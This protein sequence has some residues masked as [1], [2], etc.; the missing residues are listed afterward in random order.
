MIAILGK[1]GPP[2]ER[3]VLAGLNAV[4]YETEPPVTRR[5]GNAIIG[6][7]PRRGLAHEHLSAR[8][9]WACILWGQLD[10][11]QVLRRE[12]GMSENDGTN[13]ADVVE[14]AIR[15][16]GPTVVRRFRG[17]FAGVVTDGRSLWAFRDHVGFAPLFFRDDANAFTVAGISRQV[18]VAAGIREEPNLDVLEVMLFSSQ[19]SGTLPALKGVKRLAQGCVATF[20]DAA[21]LRIERFWHPH[22]LLETRRIS[23]PDAREEFLALLKQASERVLTGRDVLFLSGGL[24]SPMVAAYAAPEYRRRFG[25]P[26]PALTAVFPDLPNVDESDYARLVADRFGME[27]RTWRPT[28]RTLD[29]VAAWSAKL[30]TPVPT[31]SV[32]EVWEAYSLVAGSGLQNVITGEFAELTFGK[33][34]QMLPYLF[35]RGRLRALWRVMRAEHARG[36]G[37]RGLVFDALSAFVPGRVLNWRAKRGVG[38]ALEPTPDWIRLAPVDVKTPRRD[39]MVPARERWRQL[40]LAGTAG[41][42]ISMEADA[43]C[44]LMAGVVIRRPLADIDLWE[45][46]LSLPADVKF[47]VLEWKALAR[48][49]L[50]GVLP[51][52][53]LTRRKTVFDDHVMQQIDYGALDRFLLE[54]AHQMPQVDYV[55]LADRIKRRALGFHD[56]IW[57][58]ELVRIHAFLEAYR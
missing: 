8:G 46:F 58:R 51:E 2:D 22:E 34:P 43:I 38:P 41:S 10:N 49:A 39:L 9:E 16:L 33:W 48:R 28:A 3:A 20:D 50:N 24:D 7:A 54:P 40:Q 44:G 1:G 35:A 12:L 13:D 31:L 15:R 11:A 25:R 42:T 23:E 36:A 37:R 4:P 56:W 57:A 47:P 18:V 55:V 30:G 32:P 21:K 27:Y 52:E 17:T 53:I 5:I 19:P 6:V 29:D 14:A 26:L 45:F